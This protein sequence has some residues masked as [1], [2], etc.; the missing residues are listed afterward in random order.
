MAEED[1]SSGSS[2]TGG[3]VTGTTCLYAVYDPV[4]R[5]CTLASA[6]HYPPAVVHPD[7]TVEFPRLPAGPPLGLGGLPFE[8]AELDLADGT[9]LALFTNGLLL[10]RDRDIDVGL[11]A[12]RRSLSHPDRPL[13]QICDQVAATLL[14]LRPPDD[15][16]LLVARTHA[17]GTDRVASWDLTAAPAVVVDARSLAA[18]KLTEW[19]LEE[20]SFIAELVVSELVT[21]AIRYG[22]PPIRLRLIRG[23]N[24]ICEVSDSS[25]TS[26]R[27]RRAGADDEGGRG[28]FLVAQLTQRW[29]T[30][31]TPNG[32]TIWTEL[33]P[34]H[35]M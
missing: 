30:R 28:L 12:L 9:V 24:L 8:T 3:T 34:P 18:R 4:E 14:P 10:G 13:E 21:N 16:A 29:G 31:Y 11:Q 25:S 2:P 27:M 7:G 32:K 19:G 6:G 23:T 35:A 1:G 5:R 26:P 22:L 33:A 17:L 15:V 20:I